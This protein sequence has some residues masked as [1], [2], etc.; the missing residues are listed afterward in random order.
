MGMA[1]G[2]SID[3]CT[4]RGAAPRFGDEATR[5]ATALATLR[6]RLD[7]CGM[8]W[9]D[10]KAGQ[11]F[12]VQYL[13]HRPDIENA[14]DVLALGLVSINEALCTMADNHDGADHVGTIANP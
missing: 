10:D 13:P 9:G 1:G 6:A 4:L 12:A 7:A 8:P 2:F 3:T 5:L 14:L 11:G